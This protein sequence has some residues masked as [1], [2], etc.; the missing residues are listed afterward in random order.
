MKITMTAIR[1]W[2]RERFYVYKKKKNS[3]LFHVQKATQ[4]A[5]SKTISVMFLYT[6]SKTLYVTRFFMKM[7][8][9][10]LY[11]KSMTLCVIW[12][13]YIK[14]NQ[15]LLKKQDNLS[16]VLYTKIGT[17]CV[18]R[19]FIEFLKLAEGGDIFVCKK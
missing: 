14:K 15:T 19:F 7:F 16:Y 6:K 13:L 3:K 5:K 1:E 10:A 9:L 2:Q 12:C 11:T 4:F 8:K 18:M 17:L